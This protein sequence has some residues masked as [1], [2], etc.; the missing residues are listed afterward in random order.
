MLTTRLKISLA[1]S[2]LILCASP[3]FAQLSN[4]SFESFTSLPNALGQ[5]NKVDNWS[6]AS[7]NS[8]SPDYYHHHG[9]GDVD[10]PNSLGATV[11][12]WD[13]DGV[14]GFI[15]A[16]TPNSDKREYLSTS[17]EYPLTVGK[18][19]LMSFRLTNGFITSNSFMGYG[20]NH[21]GVAMTTAEPMQ[22]EDSPMFLNTQFEIDSVFFDRDWQLVSFIFT[23]DAAFTHMTVGVFTDD[24]N[25]NFEAHE[26][27]A[28]LAY[29]FVDDFFLMEL[30]DDYDP[31][32]A[33]QNKGDDG[34]SSTGGV[35]EDDGDAGPGKEPFFIPNAFTPNSDGDNDFFVPITYYNGVL[36][37]YRF[38]VFDRWGNMIF[39]TE[40]LNTG[41]DGNFQG[42]P[43]ETGVYV[44]NITYNEI[45]GEQK[46]VRNFNGSVNLIR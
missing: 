30:P 12:A 23:P 22:V 26:S 19:Y 17:F 31:T 34:G 11:N 42:T 29:Y 13:G 36:D 32:L 28:Q 14:M 1:I 16:G 41:W 40:E 4:G 6:N 43:L 8:S 15:A 37:E 3:L 45:K 21:F 25:L 18:Q 46:F 9:M 5:F 7:S 38:E 2:V 24:D 10:L 39:A 44:L 20:V 27:S 33:D 35:I